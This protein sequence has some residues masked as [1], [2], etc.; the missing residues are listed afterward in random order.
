MWKWNCPQTP[1]L[2]WESHSWSSLNEHLTVHEEGFTLPNGRHVPGCEETHD[3]WDDGKPCGL[4]ACK[5][6]YVPD[7]EG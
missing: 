7:V 5:I 3:Y 6:P 4:S 1:N 2:N